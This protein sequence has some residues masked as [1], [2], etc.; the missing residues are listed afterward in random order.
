MST[1]QTTTLSEPTGSDKIAS[2]MLTY[3]RARLKHRIYTL[4]VNELKRKG[5]SQAT[6]ARRLDKEPARVSRIFSG[7]GNLTLETVSDL[8][9]AIGGSELGLSIEYPLAKS[10]TTAEKQEPSPAPVPPR[11]ATP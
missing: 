9:F 2:W 11:P 3:F 6:L 4:V 5:I 1:L 8:L 7:P 10:V